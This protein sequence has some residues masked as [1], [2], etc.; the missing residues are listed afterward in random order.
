RAVDSEADEH[1]AH[2]NPAP[3]TSTRT[4]SI[5]PS[6]LSAM[7]GPLPVLVQR[8]RGRRGASPRTQGERKGGPGGDG[9]VLGAPRRPR[10]ARGG[11]APARPPPPPAAAAQ[12]SRGAP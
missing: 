5:A 1:E 12:T 9:G 2:G 8:E 6:R 11:R 7:A 3:G 4:R 10:R